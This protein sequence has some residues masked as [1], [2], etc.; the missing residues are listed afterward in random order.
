MQ[1]QLPP[2]LLRMATLLLPSLRLLPSL[3]PLPL[4]LLLLL[5]LLV[6]PCCA[7]RPITSL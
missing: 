5:L 1:P 3:Q 7:S 2:L 4:P 6:C